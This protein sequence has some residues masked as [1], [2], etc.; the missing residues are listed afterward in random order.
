[1][2]FSTWNVDVN[3]IGYLPGK[4][5]DVSKSTSV[6]KKLDQRQQKYTNKRTKKNSTKKKRSKK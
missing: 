5:Q 3:R 2:L 6:F 1:M 4:E